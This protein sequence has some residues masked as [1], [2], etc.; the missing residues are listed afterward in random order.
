MPQCINCAAPLPKSGIICQY[1][2]TRNDIDLHDIKNFTSIRPH[3]SRTCPVC[4][5]SLHTIDIGE[6]EPFYIE[7]CESCYGIFFDVNELETMVENSVKGSRN[8]DLH[9]LAQ[10]SE[11]PRHI[12]I[13]VYRRCPVCRKLMLRKNFMKRSGVITDVCAEHGVWLDSGELRQIMEWVKTGGIEKIKQQTEINDRATADK[14]M[15][16]YQRQYKRKMNHYHERRE[17]KHHDHNEHFDI[18]EMLSDLFFSRRW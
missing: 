7:R 17:K 14:E 4:H 5:T 3:Q 12:D 10:L 15:L 2:G 8:V 16:Q 11:H 6:N 18:F 1:C 13:I 9:K